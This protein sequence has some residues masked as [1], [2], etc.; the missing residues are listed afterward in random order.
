MWVTYTT[1]IELT[2]EKYLTIA[3]TPKN[4]QWGEMM[5]AIPEWLYMKDKLID[6]TLYGE[7][8]NFYIKVKAAFWNNK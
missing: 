3:K 1:K 7:P 8:G 6:L 5:K 2:E 4:E